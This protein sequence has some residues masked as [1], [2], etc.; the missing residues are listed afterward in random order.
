M[1][2]LLERAVAAD[3][4]PDLI[5]PI[6]LH[7]RRLRQRSYNQSLL[8]AKQIGKLRSLPVVSGL[9]LKGRDTLPQQGLSAR[10]REKNLH[11]AFTVAGRLDGKKVLLVDDV[12]TTGATAA[13]ASRVLLQQ[14]ALEIRV[15]VLARAS[16]ET[17]L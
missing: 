7:R 10:Q 1:A 11:T 17:P 16:S 3:W 14:G 12:M 5:V 9:L 15:A 6:P 2:R 4:S 8:L 13:A